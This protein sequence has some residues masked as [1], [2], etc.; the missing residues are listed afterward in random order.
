MNKILIL[1]G[2]ML[3]ASFR[4]GAQTAT[5]YIYQGRFNSQFERGTFYREY[6]GQ[7]IIAGDRSLFTMKAEGDHDAGLQQQTF[8]LRPDSLFTVYKDME[9]QSLLF[10]HSDLTQR[11]YFYA[12]TL[13]PMEWK[14]EN[15]EKMIGGIPCRKAVTRF[16]GRGYT[17]WYAPSITKMEG[18]WKLGGLP[19]LILE[20]YDDEGNWHMSYVAQMPVPIFDTG[21]FENRISKGL[22]GFPAYATALKKTMEKLQAA[23]G[24]ASSPPCIGCQTTP[25]L[26]LFSW[27]KID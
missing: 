21:Y 12:D 14:M 13:F 4:L 8:D 2:M 10:E 9:S 1:A 15:E 24:G 5:M 6:Q 25:T 16:R 3:V 27:E 19:G 17:A 20:A 18:P 11:S 22:P 26:K 23:F 7:L